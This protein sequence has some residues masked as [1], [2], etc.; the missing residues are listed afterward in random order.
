MIAALIEV[1]RHG[2]PTKRGFAAYAYA[3]L[4][5]VPLVATGSSW[6]YKDTGAD[7]GTGWRAPGYGDGAWAAGP[8]PLGYGQAGIAT[9]VSYGP[10]PNGKWV[11]TYFRKTFDVPSPSQYLAVRLRLQ[12]DDGAIVFLNN[13]E[14]LRS[15][16]Q[17]GSSYT[18]LT[19]AL[20]D[21]TGDGETA[22]QTVYIPAALLNAGANTLAVELHQ[23]SV[24]TPDARFDLDSVAGML[25]PTKTRSR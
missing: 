4:E 25:I 17:E 3:D 1:L 13:T 5:E 18:F 10:N 24:A 20:A 2:H 9:T 19:F 15:N 6:K 12:K 23:F 21:V 7:L 11:T 14:V 8:A 16:F 22:F